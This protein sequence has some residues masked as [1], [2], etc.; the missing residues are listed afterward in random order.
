LRFSPLNRWAPLPGPHFVNCGNILMSLRVS[1]TRF[2]FFFGGLSFPEN[3]L[4]A[5]G[6]F[7]FFLSYRVTV[8]VGLLFHVC[9]FIRFF[10]PEILFFFSNRSFPRCKDQ[11]FFPL[12][13][14]FSSVKISF[15]PPRMRTFRKPFVPLVLVRRNRYRDSFTVDS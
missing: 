11:S 10:F 2:H 3:F 7:F 9:V 13:V 5:H 4:R 6:F 15:C 12:V 8:L 14:G 1:S